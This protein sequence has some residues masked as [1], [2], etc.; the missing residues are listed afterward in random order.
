MNDDVTY[1]CDLCGQ[2]AI[3]VDGKYQ[4]AEA[5]DAAFCQLVMRAGG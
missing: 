3:L 4:H 1:A 2:P 5:A